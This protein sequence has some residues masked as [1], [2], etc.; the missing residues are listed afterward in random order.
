[1]SHNI[2]VEGGTSVRLPTSGKYCDRD[3]VV[4]ATGGGGGGSL[5]EGITA[6]AS[7][8][9]TP[10]GSTANYT[11]IHHGLGVAPNFFFIYI[12]GDNISNIDVASSFVTELGLLQS[13]NGTLGSGIGFKFC[14]YCNANNFI[15]MNHVPSTRELFSTDS[16]FV[17]YTPTAS[18]F[19]VGATYR[20][21][22]GVLDGI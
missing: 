19:K 2:T 21:I 18:P 4:T 12:E 6:L 22:A 7:G 16:H 13:F 9:Y 20:W 11:N 3:I 1:M 17:V 5:P 14:R 10:V 8:T 15:L